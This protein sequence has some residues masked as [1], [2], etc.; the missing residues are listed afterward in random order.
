M[1]ASESTPTCCGRNCCQLA[2]VNCFE[3]SS[4]SVRE[5]S[6][7]QTQSGAIGNNLLN[8]FD[9]ESNPVSRLALYYVDGSAET[10]E[11]KGVDNIA[12]R[13]AAD[14]NP[15]NA[16][17]N[18]GGDVFQARRPGI[19]NGHLTLFTQVDHQIKRLLVLAGLSAITSLIASTLIS[20]LKQIS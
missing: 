9:L 18:G 3:R 12:G 11:S 5:R 10:T 14:D 16:E 2:V 7:S 4:L 20:N 15:G 8:N 19:T 6:L 13:P 17:V 1:V